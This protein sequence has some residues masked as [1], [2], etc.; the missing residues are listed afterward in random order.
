MRGTQNRIQYYTLCIGEFAL[1]KNLSIKDAFLYLRNFKGIAFLIDC[2][3]AEHTLSLNDAVND[4]A[5]VCR[6]HGGSIE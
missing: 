4:L 3:D 2:Y 5:L 1:Q 6:R